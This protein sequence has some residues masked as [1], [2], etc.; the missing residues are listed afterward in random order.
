MCA[1][2]TLS[3]SVVGF[4]RGSILTRFGEDFFAQ[5]LAALVLQCGVHGEGDDGSSGAGH[6]ASPGPHAG[7]TGPRE[8][9]AR[10][11]LHGLRGNRERGSG[12]E[13][14]AGPGSV[15]SRVSAHC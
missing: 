13:G 8:N 6:W 14:L 7:R 10:G 11:P 12:M 15:T 4:E 3:C 9:R 2:G 1:T 5:G